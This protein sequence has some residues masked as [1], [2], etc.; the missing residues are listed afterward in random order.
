MRGF[1]KQRIILI[2]LIAVVATFFPTKMAIAYAQRDGKL[3]ANPQVAKRSPY[4]VVMDLAKQYHT[5][6]S[7]VFPN[8]IRIA[9]RFHVNGYII[10]ALNKVRRRI[11]PNLAPL[12]R[13]K[14]KQYKHLLNKRNNQLSTPE[15]KNLKTLLSY[16]SKLMETYEYKEAPAEWYDYSPNYKSA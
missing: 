15:L 8:A 11:S 12:A 5:F 1:E 3:L 14:L 16:S 7:N 2:T 13:L 9:D 6:V 4:A 10:E